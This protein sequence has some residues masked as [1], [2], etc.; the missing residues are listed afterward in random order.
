MLAS[1]SRSPSP[2]SPHSEPDAEG[3]TLEGDFLCLPDTASAGRLVVLDPRKNGGSGL[4]WMEGE[5]LRDHVEASYLGSGLETFPRARLRGVRITP[6]EEEVLCR[7]DRAEAGAEM[8]L[9]RL[10]VALAA[11]QMGN[12][13]AARR[14]AEQY[15]RE[16]VQ[17]GRIIIEHQEVRKTLVRMETLLEAGRSLVTRVAA[18]ADAPDRQRILAEQAHRFCD[19]AAE[20]ICLDAIQ[21]LGG[22]GYMKDYGLERRLRDCK[23]LQGLLGSHPVDWLGGEG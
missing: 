4:Y 9:T 23:A 7:G 15:A 2:V 21:V 6:A 3:P 20:S 12:A 17:T 14:E 1:P 8:L 10:R 5:R 13:G 19:E 18:C 22:Y 11:V 16:R